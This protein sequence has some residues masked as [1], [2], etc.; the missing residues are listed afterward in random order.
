[1]SWAIY[2]GHSN[3]Q[4]LKVQQ[5]RAIKHMG[6]SLEY[7]GYLTFF[8]TLFMGPLISLKDYRMICAMVICDLCRN[9]NV[10]FK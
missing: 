7:F 5:E 8:P 6:S 10:P 3:P 9:L 2:D 1:M 4:P